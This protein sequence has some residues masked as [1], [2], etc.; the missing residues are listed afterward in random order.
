MLRK[1]E[2]F[3]QER[4]YLMNI[5]PATVRWYTHNFKW[6]PSE[7]PTEAELNLMVVRMRQKGMRATGC[8]SVIRSVNA[9]LHWASDNHGSPCGASCTHLRLRQMKEPEYE[10]EMFTDE[11][12]T[13]LLRWKPRTTAEH[14]WAMLIAFLL[15]TGARVGE[16]LS[17]TWADCDFDNLLVTLRGKG[18]KSRRIPMSLECRKRL[19]LWQKKSNGR[20]GLVFGTFGGTMLGRRNVLR[21]IKGICRKLGFKP[22]ARTVHAFRHSFAT[23]YLKAGGSVF[24]LQ[25]QLGHSTLEMTRRYSHLVVSDLQQVHEQ[26]TLLS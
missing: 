26:L 24:H 12:V 14:R 17:L 21:A 11:Q 7:N 15:D 10:P 25:R 19:F 13:R 23:H 4:Q 9:Y 1:L 16:C 8:N 6:L 3:V 20:T 2:Q 5:S 22:P 18:R